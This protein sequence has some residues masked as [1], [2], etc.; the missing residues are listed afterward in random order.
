[1]KKVTLITTEALS[2]YNKD[3]VFTVSAEEA[4]K[5]LKSDV[6]HKVKKFD[7]KNPDHV[8]KLEAQR[9]KPMDQDA[10]AGPEPDSKPA[11][12]VDTKALKDEL[13]ADVKKEAGKIVEAAKADAEKI[14]ADAQAK[15]EETLAD[16]EK[17][18]KDEV[19]KAVA[20]ATKK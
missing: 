12:A 15:A 16:A 18:V 2:P 11:P 20:E 1:M 13:L 4:E 10:E 7:P 6:G 17:I 19:T 5:L 14:V 9:G 3:E 8:A